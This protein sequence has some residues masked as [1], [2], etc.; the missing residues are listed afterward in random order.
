MGMNATLRRL[1]DDDLSRLLDDPDLVPPYLIHEQLPDGF[2]PIIELNLEESWHA[3][4]FLLTGSAWAGK[5]PLNFVATGGEEL[6]EEGGH[7]PARSLSASQVRKL[8]AAL[9]RCPTEAL[10]KRFDPAALTAADVY[11]GTW[12]R[13]AQGQ[14][15]RGYVGAHYD[16]LRKFVMQ[17]A[18]AR[19]ALIISIT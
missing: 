11:P 5:A 14:D 8:A 10:L 6:G 13:P 4:H 7:A 19:Q 9:D 18:G 3:I 15:M 1:S 17:A 2:G 16:K 12:S